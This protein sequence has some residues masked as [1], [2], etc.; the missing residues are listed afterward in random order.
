MNTIVKF[1]AV[2]LLSAGLMQG[3]AWVDLKPQGEKVRILAAQEVGRC[4]ELGRVSAT[5]AAKVGFIARPKGDVQE[6][7][8]RLARNNAADMGGDTVV[9]IGPLIDGEQLFKVYR[10]INP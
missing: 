9:A 7:V 6:E 3:C 5:T 4:K 8:Y 2:G 1:V 10:C